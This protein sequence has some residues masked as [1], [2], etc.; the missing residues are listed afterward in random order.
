MT[1]FLRLLAEEDKRTALRSSCAR[2][3]QDTEHGLCF[4][5]NPEDFAAIPGK[6]F[7]YWVSHAVRNT[8]RKL[9]AFE[10]EGRTVKQGLATADDLRFLRGWWEPVRV[11]VVRKW[12]PFAKGGVYSPFYADIFMVVNWASDGAEIRNNLNEKGG[13]RSNVWMLNDTAARYFYRPGLT[14]PLRSRNFAPQALP[15]ECIFSVR[16]YCAFPEPGDELKTLAVFN[17]RAFDYLYKTAL[18]RFGVPEFI[19]GILQIMPWANAST[20]VR[21][22]LSGLARRAW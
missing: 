20:E 22:V 17:S 1:V 21:Q 6:P 10:G 7:A 2:I 8:F 13:V 9:P 5:V 15:A 4:V 14:W 19:V 11:D 12:R 3:R 16:G 18:G